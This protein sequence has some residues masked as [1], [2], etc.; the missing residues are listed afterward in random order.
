MKVRMRQIALI[1]GGLG[2]L[3]FPLPFSRG[4]EAS[5]A[6]EVQLMRVAEVRAGMR[7]TA[8]TVIQ[9][10][11]I[12]TFDVEVLGVMKGAGPSGD[13]ILIRASGAVIA[14]S[15]GIAAGM[16]GSP[17]FIK[18]RLLGAIGYGWSFSE[19][20]LGLVTPIET[21]LTAAPA[22]RAQR[23]S[24]R[25]PVPV[26]VAGRT[27][28][29]ALVQHSVASF[30]PVGGATTDD[31]IIFRPVAVPMIIAGMGPR[32]AD[33]LAQVL[34]PYG[35][36]PVGGGGGGHLAAEIPL[37][38]GS[39]MGVQLMRG[40]VN[41]TA[42]GT[43]TYRRGTMVLG[44]GH[45]FLNKGGVEFMLTPAVIHEVVRSLA[46]PFK[47][48]SP[49]AVV[50]VVQEDRRAAVGG[51]TQLVPKVIVIR[52]TVRDVDR[53]TRTHLAMH[54]VRDPELGP[55]VALLG[56]LEA[57]DRAL[58]RVGGGT[59][60]LQLTMRGQGLP[61]AL[62]RT[63]VFYHSRDVSAGALAELPEALRL[64]FR[65]EFVAVEPVDLSIE[66]E[67]SRER[68]TASIVEVT[69]QRTRV[70]AGESFAVSIVLRPFHGEPVTRTVEVMVPE[71]FPAGQAVLVVRGG[72]D[73][74]EEPLANL[75]LIENT[76]SG[77]RTLAEQIAAFQERDQNTQL[78]VELIGG[79]RPSDR[80]AGRPKVR[81]RTPWVIRGRHQIAVQV[82][83]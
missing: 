28:R 81:D 83:R 10:T 72:H 21:M 42:I 82:E 51:Q 48:G 13:L 76:D 47:I 33:I 4:A 19:H 9:G 61:D 14:R 68:H 36:I 16:S 80:A 2:L 23:G 73:A 45:A 74:P 12:E 39:A 29:K 49:G 55:A 15:G 77:A 64:L 63:N 25:L 75:L 5:P 43:V 11:R 56:V 50:G 78:V 60:R 26:T 37:Q 44:F 17:V 22:K 27:Y 41:L 57:F 34:R 67:V 65:N 24:Y 52:V 31:T 32:A 1:A 69:P 53:K 35:V 18:D 30:S 40:D 46:S 66:A 70:R 59:A 38:P 79:I 20:T 54:A 7:G 6:E 8:R 62:R 58:D 71:N 3:L